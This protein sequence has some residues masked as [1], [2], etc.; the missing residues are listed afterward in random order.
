MHHGVALRPNEAESAQM[1]VDSLDQI[2]PG[3]AL[4]EGLG[5]PKIVLGLWCLRKAFF[6]LLWLGLAVAVLALGDLETLDSSMPSFDN[7]GELLSNL[8]SPFGLIV[9]AFGVRIGANLLGLAVSFP[10]TLRT[11]PSDYKT[12]WNVTAWLRVW[13]DRWRLAGAYRSLRWTWAVRNL[14]R[15]RLGDSAKPFRI[16]ELVLRWA[17]VLLTLSFFVIV[18]AIG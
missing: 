18:I 15:Q 12:G 11:R 17:S 8:L 14:A 5:D 13:W 4:R 2:D 7:P 1:A 9:L 6:P 3:L 16:C 10:L